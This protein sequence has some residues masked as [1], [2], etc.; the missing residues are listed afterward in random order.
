MHPFSRWPR[1]RAAPQCRNFDR[2]SAASRASRTSRALPDLT[3]GTFLTFLLLTGLIGSAF[4]AVSHGRSAVGTIAVA[5]IR[6]GMRGFGLSVFRGTEP[7]RFD[8]EVIDVLHRFRP[9]QD[10]ILVRTP[11][12]RLNEAKAVAGMSGSPIYLEGKLAGAYAYGWPFGTEPVVGV[13]PIKDMLAE[14]A[15]PLVPE[16]WQMLGPV[17][18]G[19][20]GH[21]P[22]PTERK[23]GVASVSPSLH[24]GGGLPAYRGERHHSALWAVRQFRSQQTQRHPGQVEM[25]QTPLMVA[26]LSNASTTLLATELSPFGML[27]VQAGGAGPAPTRGTSRRGYRDGGAIGVQ[28][29]GG[30]ISATAVGTVTHVAGNRLLAFGHPMMNV[31]QTAMPTTTAEV[32]HILANQQRSFKM[33]RP[34]QAQGTL[35]QDRQAAVVVDAERTPETIPVEIKLHGPALPTLAKMPAP[36]TD[37]HLEV[38]SNRNLTPLLL[39]SGMLNALQAVVSDRTDVVFVARQRVTIPGHGTLELVDDGHL[40]GGLASAET[41]QQLRVFS[42]IDAAYGNP[43]ERA[44][45][46]ELAIDI[47]LSYADDTLEIAALRVPY[48]EVEPGSDLPVHVTFRTYHG[49]EQLKTVYLPVPRSAAGQNITISATAGSMVHPPLPIARN[50]DDVLDNLKHGYRATLL[51]LAIELPSQGVRLLGHVAE[52]LPGSVLNSLQTDSLDAPKQLFRDEQRFAID[53]PQVLY[54]AAKVQLQVKDKAER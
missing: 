25:A 6:P 47:E 33:S 51:V 29:I 26:G 30:D 43:F 49:R 16:I 2:T 12:P 48:N 23:P 39:F 36:K 18:A 3:N 38:A 1:R 31:G 27:A 8:V 41:M 11:H 5:D 45:I 22:A 37:W 21:K 54:G 50:L 9:A 13:T 10:L 40:V 28:L 53:M 24:S 46:S 35:V 14:L 52:R 4:V 15:R 42:A 44:H 7:E 19:A 17:P 32:V 20:Q 34:L